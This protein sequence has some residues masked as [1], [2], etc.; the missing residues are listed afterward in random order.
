MGTEGRQI[1]TRNITIAGL[2]NEYNLFYNQ[3]LS[4]TRNTLKTLRSRE[5]FF[6][7][8]HNIGFRKVITGKFPKEQLMFQEPTLMISYLTQ[9]DGVITSRIGGNLGMLKDKMRPISGYHYIHFVETIQAPFDSTVIRVIKNNVSILD[10]YQNRNLFIIN[11]GPYNSTNEISLS[12]V[13]KFCEFIKDILTDGN[14]LVNGSLGN[15]TVRDNNIVQLTPEEIEKREVAFVTQE[16]MGVINNKII[17]MGR[18]ILNTQSSIEYMSRE[19][20]ASYGKVRR[21]YI[22]V[23]DV[24]KFKI[25]FESRFIQELYEIKQLNFVKSIKF[26]SGA[27]NINVGDIILKVANTKT[28]IGD[29]NILIYPNQVKFENKYSIGRTEHPH[30]MEGRPC[31]GSFAPNITKLLGELELKRL[32]FLLYQF[33]NTY[34]QASCYI[35]FTNWEKARKD[36]GKFDTDGSLK[37]S[38]KEKK[39]IGVKK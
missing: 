18:D 3:A 4:L 35:N 24:K 17:E 13:A 30:I 22:E 39:I 2:Q 9:I 26:K 25:N 14:L 1:N 37:V 21:L 12:I 11:L 38:D 20:V 32:V 16:F 29:M 5:I 7:M 36:E 33:L 27:I 6:K 31:L 34:N 15:I 23:E 8:L 28:Y 19:L 10:Y